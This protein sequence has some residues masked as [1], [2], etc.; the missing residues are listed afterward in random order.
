[1]E[2]FNRDLLREINAFCEK[3]K[4]SPTEFGR[5]AVKDHRFVHRLSNRDV[6]GK[7]VTA[8]RQF[9]ATYRPQGRAKR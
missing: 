7:T 1:M 2:P 3:W 9:M 6:R 8:V 4:M 5:Q